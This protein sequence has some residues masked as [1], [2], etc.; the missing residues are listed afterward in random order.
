MPFACLPKSRLKEAMHHHCQCAAHHLGQPLEDTPEARELCNPRQRRTLAR[1]RVSAYAL[2]A[3]AKAALRRGAFV[4]AMLA[5]LNRPVSW[6]SVLL[7][8]SFAVSLNIV[9]SMWL[10]AAIGCVWRGRRLTCRW[11]HSPESKGTGE[12]WR[13]AHALRPIGHV[14]QVPGKGKAMKL[15]AGGKRLAFQTQPLFDLGD[16]A[17]KHF[18]AHCFRLRRVERHGEQILFATRAHRHGLRFLHCPHDC[19]R[20]KSADFVD[21]DLFI[22][23][24]QKV[25]AEL[26]SATAL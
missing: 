22:L 8:R 7:R 5:A 6:A 19:L 26:R 16:C 13:A 10:A 2:E 23:G 15:P 18:N 25:K 11:A 14:S 3:V 9:S 12:G 1:W 24:L 17:F 21:F 20:H 4:I